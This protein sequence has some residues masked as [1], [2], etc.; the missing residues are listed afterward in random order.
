[1]GYYWEF[2]ATYPTYQP[3]YMNRI[4]SFLLAL[5]L[6][7]GS[8]SAIAQITLPP[9]GNNQKSTVSQFMG[10]VEV[11]FTYN[12]PDVHTPNGDDRRGKIWGQVVPHGLNNFGF[13]TSTQAPWR[14]GANE[15]TLF[16]AS[17]AIEVQG[18]SLPAGTY[19]FHVITAENGPWTVI[20]TTDT[21][22][23]GSY[24]YDPANDVLR[25]EAEPME[26]SYEEYLTFE[27]GDRKLES[28]T[29]VLAWEDLALPIQLS[30]PNIHDLYIANLEQELS[31]QKGFMWQNLATAANYTANYETHLEKGLE[32]AEA[33]ISRPFIG[34]PNFVT[35]GAKASVLTAMGRLEDAD[36]A[37]QSALELPATTALQIHQYGRQMLSQGQKE[38]ALEIFEY[39]AERHGDAWPVNVG[40][41]RGY[42][43]MGD[44]KKALKH[45][46][47]AQEQAP[48]ELNRN[49]L[50]S[51][52]EKL[53]N[54]EDIN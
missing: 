18:E 40:L 13:G 31:G 32:W 49:S 51:M 1:M 12:S 47:K 30:V 9:S 16:H 38:R 48:D 43:A 52:I 33:A 41:T 22:A 26:S 45:A 42:A 5:M 15:N 11:G 54:G 25:V 2:Q 19:G 46:K 29:A 7:M 23:W 39:N 27:F 34:Q 8:L 53:S 10:M 6:M 50:A 44:Y 28:C 36:A 24:F 35:Y 3:I 37:M 20:F 21:E 14:A 17:H 4:A